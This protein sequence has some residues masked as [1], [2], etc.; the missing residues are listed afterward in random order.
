MG[1]KLLRTLWEGRIAR[2]A[3]PGKERLELLVQPPTWEPGPLVKRVHLGYG[4]LYRKLRRRAV[5]GG[6]RQDAK[7]EMGGLRARQ[8]CWPL[9]IF[10]AA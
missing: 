2:G 9:R 1:D 8:E 3:W 5:L 6:T 4:T 7:I 10:V